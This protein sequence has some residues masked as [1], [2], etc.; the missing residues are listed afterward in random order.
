[1]AAAAPAGPGHAAQRGAV[2]PRGVPWRRRHS[3]HQ[4]PTDAGAGLGW[5]GRHAALRPAGAAPAGR[6]RQCSR[7]AGALRHPGRLR[8]AGR[9][10]GRPVRPGGVRWRCAGQHRR[11]ARGGAHGAAHHLRARHA[12]ARPPAG[13]AGPVDTEPGRPAGRRCRHAVAGAPGRTCTGPQTLPGCRPRRAAHGRPAADA[14]PGAPATA[15]GVADQPGLPPG[16]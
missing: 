11:P 12:A 3:G 15:G 9:V 4:Q 5:A 16:T 14:G 6:T 10:G 1:M 2:F 7:P 8:R 13:F